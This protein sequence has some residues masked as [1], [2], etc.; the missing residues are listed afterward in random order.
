MVCRFCG[1][2]IEADDLLHA[3]RCDGR[4]GTRE[5]EFHFDADPTG[6]KRPLR[7][8]GDDYVPPRDDPRL[9]R[10]YARIFA[11]MRDGAW[12]TLADIEARTGDPPASIS[13][14]LRH[15]RKQRFGGHTVNRRYLGNGLYDY[16]LL[17]RELMTQEG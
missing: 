9:T 3:L 2:D 1:E 5:A 14:Q 13:A 17:V 6:A 12:R 8:D 10:Q 11:L 15:M 4:Q 7:F 16:Q